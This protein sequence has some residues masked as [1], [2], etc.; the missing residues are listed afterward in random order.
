MYMCVHTHK[1]QHTYTTYG[2]THTKNHT[3]KSKTI[4]ILLGT[5]FDYHVVSTAWEQYPVLR[6]LIMG[7]QQKALGQGNDER[8]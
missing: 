1:H 8:V 4:A 5:H 6:E 7:G 2:C 3:S